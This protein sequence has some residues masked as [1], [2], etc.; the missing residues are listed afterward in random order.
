MS[1][2]VVFSSQDLPAQLARQRDVTHNAVCQH[3]HSAYQIVHRVLECRRRR[4]RH[5]LDA[6]E[7]GVL[8]D[9]DLGLGEVFRCT[10]RF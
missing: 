6:V 8:N 7:N 10:Q 2:C 3:K 1:A 4:L 5:Q 9:L